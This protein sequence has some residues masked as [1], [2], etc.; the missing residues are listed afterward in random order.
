MSKSSALYQALTEA[1]PMLPRQRGREHVEVLSEELLELSD[2]KEIIGV[3]SGA[4]NRASGMPVFDALQ[5]LVPLV[6]EG[7]TQ[8]VKMVGWV[9]LHHPDADVLD[10]RAAVGVHPAPRLAPVPL[11]ARHTTRPIR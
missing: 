5:H 7:M 8:S 11:R 4:T 10:H 6:P 1:V 3:R 2:V 9:A